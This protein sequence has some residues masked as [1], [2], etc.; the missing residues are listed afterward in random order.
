MMQ[1]YLSRF[2]CACVSLAKT[3]INKNTQLKSG[4]QICEMKRYA[5]CMLQGN[6]QFNEANSYIDMSNFK[7]T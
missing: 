6:M 4:K 5:F 1:S 3:N 2:R 7:N